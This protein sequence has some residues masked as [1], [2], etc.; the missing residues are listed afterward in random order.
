VAVVISTG[1]GQP[2]G[3]QPGGGHP[4]RSTVLTAAMVRHVASASA[5]ALAT[6]GRAV[7]TYRTSQNGTLQVAGADN[8]TFAGKDWNDSLSQSF[9]AS[10][11]TA[12]SSQHAIN[13]DVGGHFYLYT[14]GASGTW[15]W[16]RDTNPSGH[17]SVT[18]PN[19]R[20]LL[21]VLRPEARFV[22][23]GYQVIDGVRLQ[24]LRATQPGGVP[25][26]DTLF[27]TMPGG[28]P[29]ALTVW[30]DG[31]DVV[32]LMDA[33]LR[34]VTNTS[35]GDVLKRDSHGHL[36]ILVANQ[37]LLKEFRAALAKKNPQHMVVRIDHHLRV[38]THHEVQLTGVSVTFSDIG[39]PQ[40][41][42]V[43]RHAV[44]VFGRG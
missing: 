11:S 39:Q 34:S 29:T 32:R 14:I 25:Q 33:T 26:L 23:I 5:V 22:S 2:G 38:T 24:G 17:P 6:S 37:A 30:V 36:T 8:V 41:I 40:H 43:P 15:E 21:G 4:A 44:G 1:G 20:Q 19:P 7:I 35:S 31:H 16:I 9:P 10:G 28:R 3:G 12:A 13:R 27:S 18:A 42:V